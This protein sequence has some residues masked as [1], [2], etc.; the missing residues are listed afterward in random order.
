MDYSALYAEAESLVKGGGSPS[1]HLKKLCDMLKDKVPHYNWFGFYITGAGQKDLNLGPFAGE[2]TEHVKIA[3]GQGICGQ[4]A[5][6]AEAFI[7]GD[8][9]KE[10]NYLA[11]S[12]KV[13]SEI[14]VPVFAP[15]AFDY[16]KGKGKGEVI[17]EIDIDSWTAGAFTDEDNDFLESLAILVAGDVDAL[18]KAG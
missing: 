6:K 1:D 9:S 14:V 5:D 18:H 4:A 12:V 2:P 15:G 16:D 3:F 13:K 8:V 7:V 11:C 17:G 10:S